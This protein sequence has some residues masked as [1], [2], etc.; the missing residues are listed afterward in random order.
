[1]AETLTVCSNKLHQKEWMNLTCVIKGGRLRHGKVP[2]RLRSK[3]GRALE[4]KTWRAWE[5]NSLACCPMSTSHYL[6]RECSESWSLKWEQE[7]SPQHLPT[8][9]WCD[10]KATKDVVTI[11]FLKNGTWA[12]GIYFCDHKS[13]PE[14]SSR[15]A[16]DIAG[17]PKSK[18]LWWLEICVNLTRPGCLT[19]FL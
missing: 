17:W 8:L 1:M 4:G 7:F 10:L 6:G 19:S 9:W 18:C 15:A 5:P 3:R 14:Q 16:G 13:G 12:P 2:T 11:S